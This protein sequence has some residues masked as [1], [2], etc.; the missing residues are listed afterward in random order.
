VLW[1]CCRDSGSEF[2]KYFNFYFLTG[3]IFIAVVT[4]SYLALHL[5]SD[6]TNQLNINFTNECVL[7]K[8]M[9]DEEKKTIASF[10]CETKKLYFS[11][12]YGFV[13]ID[14]SLAMII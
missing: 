5:F 2:L 3:D 11:S 10:F 13:L 9:N 8:L 12:A 7:E 6:Q 4:D 1:Y 14:W